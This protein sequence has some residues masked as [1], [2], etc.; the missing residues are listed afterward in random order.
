[1][2][3]LATTPFFMAVLAAASVSSATSIDEDLWAQSGGALQNAAWS[4]DQTNYVMSI[5][6]QQY[7]SPGN[8][9]GWFTTDSSA[10]PTITMENAI[11]NDTG[12]AW[13]SYDVNV[14]MNQQFTLSAPVVYPDTTEPHWSGTI[15]DSPAVWNGAQWEAQAIFEGG[16]PLP[17]GGVLDFGYQASFTG[18]VDFTQ[19]LVPVPEPGALPLIFGAVAGL[20]AIGRKM[21]L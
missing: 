7:L 6:A 1:M 9:L 21:G 5:G 20:L 12:F 19:Q 17:V 14:Y 4:W 18:N 11:D 2:R 16:T 3:I 8:V 15:T 13:T 10:D